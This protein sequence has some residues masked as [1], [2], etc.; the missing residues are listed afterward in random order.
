MLQKVCLFNIVFSYSFCY[1]LP[2]AYSR[3]MNYRLKNKINK[4]KRVHCYFIIRNSIILT[5]KFK[6]YLNNLPVE[7]SV[8]TP[9]WD[10]ESF[11]IPHTCLPVHLTHNNGW[12]NNQIHLKIRMFVCWTEIPTLFFFTEFNWFR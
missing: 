6:R 3:I 5:T 4:F 1:I 7:T 12:K 10:W 8:W 2:T 11:W 9:C